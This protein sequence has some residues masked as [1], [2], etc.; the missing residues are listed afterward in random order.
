MALRPSSRVPV[1]TFDP[2]PSSLQHAQT[3]L[4]R[5]R[6]WIR[7]AVNECS[8]ESYLTVLCQD[9]ALSG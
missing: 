8:L 1:L 6:A 5:G 9:G 3:D 2:S 7:L 4:G